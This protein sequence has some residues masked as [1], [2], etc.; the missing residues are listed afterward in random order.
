MS[1][2]IFFVSLIRPD[3]VINKKQ[4]SFHD[5]G[6]IGIFLPFDKDISDIVRVMMPLY[7]KIMK[8]FLAA[9]LVSAMIFLISGFPQPLFSQY[10][11]FS[12]QPAPGASVWV[13]V[14]GYFVD[15]KGV[16]TAQN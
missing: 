12:F 8:I 3:D 7:Q 14:P 1:A 15:M 16:K 11:L 9:F 4:E 6:K 2:V 5:V 13:S 10:L